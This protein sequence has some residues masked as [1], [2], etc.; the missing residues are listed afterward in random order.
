MQYIVTYDNIGTLAKIKK[1]PFQTTVY[2][3]KVLNLIVLDASYQSKQVKEEL[4]NIKGVMS[5]T[6]PK[7]PIFNN[8]Q[9]MYRF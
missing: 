5:I 2:Q 4:S 9:Y 3:S 1:I 8:K 6:Y 7:R